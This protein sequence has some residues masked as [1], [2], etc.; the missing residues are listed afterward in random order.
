[1]IRTKIAVIGCG[2][3][4]PK[5][6]SGLRKIPGVDIVL[7]DANE[8]FARRLAEQ[9]NLP[10]TE[11][12]EDVFADDSVDAVDICTP[13]PTHA[14]LIT[15]ALNSG[16]DFFCE[17]P[18]CQTLDEARA[19]ENL[20]NQ[21][22][23]IGMVGYIYRFAPIFELGHKLFHKV[24]A[25][26]ESRTLGAIT[27]VHF[28]LGGRGS[29]QLWKHRRETGGGAINEMLVHMVDLAIWYF[30]PPVNVEV[31]TCDLLRKQREIQG[32]VYDVDAEDYVL[33]RLR[34]KNGIVVYC[35]ADLVTPTFTQFVEVQG[36]FGT[37]FGSIQQD[38]PSFLFLQREVAGY[39]AGMNTFN[40][41]H[42]NLFEAQMAEFVDA[43]QAEK[44]PAR[45]AVKDSILLMEAM[46]KIQQ[47]ISL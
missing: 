7:A 26:G 43:V 24:R 20:V 4:A 25:N 27:V 28:R 41:G 34:M 29:H 11:K 10:W 12:V 33:V 47:D 39:Q 2:K 37:F 31:L 16:K 17:K 32:V 21:T 14:G 3:Q 38:M 40:F 42:L 9:E 36:E 8:S 30:G 22:A 35:Q 46:D 23:R 45:S 5:H 15:A 44:Q 18:L 13:T 1:M 6:I 19:I